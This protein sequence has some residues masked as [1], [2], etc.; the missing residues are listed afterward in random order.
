VP[1]TLNAE[2]YQ[3][4]LTDEGVLADMQAFFGERNGYFQ[5]DGAPA[6][7][8]KTTVKMIEEQI[9]LIRDWP[10]NS[11]DLSVIENLWGIL[12]RKASERSPKTVHELKQAVFDEW[13]NLDQETIDALVDTTTEKFKMCISE[14][15]KSINHLVRKMHQPAKQLVRL[16][17]LQNGAKCIC[18][19]KQTYIGKQVTIAAQAKGARNCAHKEALHWILLLDHD[20]VT[21]GRKGPKSIQLMIPTESVASF[22]MGIP[23]LVIANLRGMCWQEAQITALDAKKSAKLTK[24]L[25]FCSVVVDDVNLEQILA[26][27]HPEEEENDEEDQP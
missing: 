22:P 12:K 23:V 20:R 7:R 5:Q 3:K 4:M 13:D 21:A 10:A 24:Y 26:V 6:H 15:G 9:G 14:E 17:V 19:L 27:H 1:E 8:A 25:E 2:R 18:Q 16:P 11:P